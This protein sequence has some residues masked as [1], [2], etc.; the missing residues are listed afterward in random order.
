MLTLPYAYGDIM[1]LN[2][3]QVVIICIWYKANVKF[4]TRHEAQL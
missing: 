4:P 3:L 1:S 2:D